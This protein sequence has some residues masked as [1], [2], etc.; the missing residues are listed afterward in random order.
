M[1]QYYDMYR[2]FKTGFN[3]TALQFDCNKKVH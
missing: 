3:Y 2:Q 1:V